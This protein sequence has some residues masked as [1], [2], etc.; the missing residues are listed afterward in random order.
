M[1]IIANETASSDE[2]EAAFQPFLVSHN[3]CPKMFIKS[4]SSMLHE[5]ALKHTEG[6]S[7]SDAFSAFISQ[8]TTKRVRE[9]ETA[10]IGI[11]GRVDPKKPKVELNP[12]INSISKNQLE[13]KIVPFTG[14]S[15]RSE[16][17]KPHDN[18]VISC[19]T[20]V[21]QTATVNDTACTKSFLNYL[22]KSHECFR[23]VGVDTN[24]IVLKRNECNQDAVTVDT[25]KIVCEKNKGVQ[26]INVHTD[27]DIRNVET[28]GR[29]DRRDVSGN[30]SRDSRSWVQR[31]L[32]LNSEQEHFWDRVSKSAGISHAELNM[33]RNICESR[34]PSRC[35][36]VTGNNV[37]AEN[38]SQN[39]R[40]NIVT[41]ETTNGPLIDLTSASRVRCVK[42][43]SNRNQNCRRTGLRSKPYNV[44]ETSPPGAYCD[45]IE[46]ATDV[47]CK[48]E[49]G[50]TLSRAR[51]NSTVSWPRCRRVSVVLE[52]LS[53][54]KIENIKSSLKYVH[55]AL[56]LLSRA[57][58][59]PSL[60][61]TPICRSEKIFN[62]SLSDKLNRIEYAAMDLE[63]G[64]HSI[65]K[66][67]KLKS[68]RISPGRK[69]YTTLVTNTES[70]PEQEF[71]N[72]EMS[73]DS[74][75]LNQSVLL[76]QLGECKR[77]KKKKSEHCILATPCKKLDGFQSP[78]AYVPNFMTHDDYGRE[79]KQNV[80]YLLPE[81]WLN[82]YG[83]CTD[84]T[85]LISNLCDS[86]KPDES[87][88]NRKLSPTKK[89]LFA[90]KFDDCVS[91]ESFYSTELVEFKKLN[92][93]K[94]FPDLNVEIADKEDC[95]FF[96]AVS[97]L[98]CKE[99]V[100][101]AEYLFHSGKSP[102][103]LLHF[104]LPDKK[105][106]N[107]ETKCTVVSKGR[108]TKTTKN[109]GKKIVEDSNGTCEEGCFS[110]LSLYAVELS[111]HETLWPPGL[112][113]NQTSHET[114][115]FQSKTPSGME[116]DIP[117]KLDMLTS[118]CEIKAAAITTDCVGTEF[119]SVKRSKRPRV[120]KVLVCNS[121]ENDGLVANL[122]KPVKCS[123]RKLSAK[124][125]KSCL[126]INKEAS[127]ASV[128]FEAKT[129]VDSLSEHVC[130]TVESVVGTLDH[131]NPKYVVSADTK[132]GNDDISTDV[133]DIATDERTVQESLFKLADTGSLQVVAGNVEVDKNEK[134]LGKTSKLYSVKKVRHPKKD[135]CKRSGSITSVDVDGPLISV[136]VTNN[137]NVS[138]VK[139]GWAPFSSIVNPDLLSVVKKGRPPKKK[140]SGNISVPNINSHV[141]V[142]V[143]D[144]GELRE[145][146][147][148][149]VPDDSCLTQ[150]TLVARKRPPRKKQPLSKL[151]Q[152]ENTLISTPVESSFVT[153]PD[154]KTITG[155]SDAVRLDCSSVQRNE[156]LDLLDRD[157]SVQRSEST[158]PVNSNWDPGFSKSCPVSDADVVQ[159]P[160]ISRPMS[161]DFV[162]EF[163]DFGP[164]GSDFVQEL[165]DTGPVNTDFI[166]CIS[167]PGPVSNDF[168]QRFC[169][170]GPV[171]GPDFVQGFS[172]VG[173]VSADFEQCRESYQSE[174]IN[175]DFV[176]SCG[177]RDSV[178]VNDDFA[179]VLNDFY[180]MNSDSVQIDS[181]SF[182]IRS[183]SVDMNHDPNAGIS[184]IE[185]I[186]DTVV[187]MLNYEGDESPSPTSAGSGYNDISSWLA[188]SMGL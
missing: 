141:S 130:R 102:A 65:A 127:I 10:F 28:G 79:I 115:V 6:S 104:H 146:S 185:N 89:S 21:K 105:Q 68:D 96:T 152:E 131:E 180:S 36:N 109:A 108:K 49:F 11:G 139:N 43:S 134:V 160:S 9:I 63:A 179:P 165:S 170:T 186:S 94:L 20:S 8:K 135:S 73:L 2:S 22:A 38:D 110:G 101:Q 159:G 118:A 116:P 66:Q 156:D 119:K 97:A 27:F 123:V 61:T 93:T 70:L 29:T 88:K 142:L 3:S 40:N 42:A 113:F 62:D 138:V 83:E 161:T 75:E 69:K 46:C 95:L 164:R 19:R 5:P 172:D 85:A 80:T 12:Q 13:N 47:Y 76:Q 157:S 132:I 67:A 176:Y 169:D 126:S 71:F 117:S 177:S 4:D 58:I 125:K 99:N 188:A 128:S 48:Y 162:Q 87:R 140:Q 144:G 15:V 150:K 91:R 111:L 41:R 25:D 121:G 107:G 98:P 147:C 120:K 168:V 103:T 82:D 86:H 124:A 158:D 60:N 137:T 182:P 1:S 77:S 57:G 44:C 52:R 163:S 55:T 33:Q 112:T 64:L 92:G 37:V 74:T 45:H 18:G 35:M 122:P 34:K 54:A 30:V 26:Q 167:D 39:S 7:F 175:T 129:N 16:F 184:H 50:T 136:L 174:R 53:D 32:G 148:A 154:D 24:E 84:I 149:Q 145:S 14:S 17:I 59:E 151:I 153:T 81:W 56:D 171:T 100:N 106:K 166:Q 114:S 181:C 23:K 183:N 78:R 51:H 133:V 143:N 72:E 155:T 90:M 178:P 31:R 187:E 173:P